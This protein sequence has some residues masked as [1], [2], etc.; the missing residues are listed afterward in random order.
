[1]EIICK[2]QGASSEDLKAGLTHRFNVFP[3]RFVGGPALCL[4][5]LHEL[6]K[7]VDKEYLESQII[8]KTFYSTAG[9]K[10]IVC[11]IQMANGSFERGEATCMNPETFVLQTGKDMA[12]HDAL[13]KTWDKEGYLLQTLR[14]VA[15]LNN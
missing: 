7:S 6:P 11:E 12:Y 10:T 4:R 15:E 13:N 3:V 8:E 1:M 9:G 14:W 5:Q 2:E